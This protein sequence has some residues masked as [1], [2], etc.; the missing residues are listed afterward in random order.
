MPGT[1][2]RRQ[3]DIV[4]ATVMRSAG[5]IWPSSLL[6]TRCGRLISDQGRAFDSDQIAATRGMIF[7]DA[8]IK[9]QPRNLER[10]L[11][12]VWAATSA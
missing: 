8:A 4:A 7:K 12:P 11:A 1:V 9:K 5:A 10:V 6:S 3:F 2:A